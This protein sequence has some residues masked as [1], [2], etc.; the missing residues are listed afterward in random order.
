MASP[1]SG[2][3]RSSGR[4]RTPGPGG[5]GRIPPRGAVPCTWLENTAE[6]APRSARRQSGPLCG[7]PPARGLLRR[8]SGIGCSEDAVTLRVILVDDHRLFRECVRSLLEREPG[9][10]VAGEAADGRDALE[11]VRCVR[12]HVVL[13]EVMMPGVSGID[14]TRIIRREHPGVAVLGFSA[15][16]ETACV[17][18]ML[19]A[20]ASGYF[21]KRLATSA[22]LG[23]AI[24]AAADGEIYFGPNIPQIIVTQYFWRLPEEVAAGS[25]G[26][27][28]KERQ[29]LAMIASGKSSK[30]ISFDLGLS[31]RA[32]EVQRTRIMKKL[33]LFSVA[34]LTKYALREGLA[35]L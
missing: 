28:P 6:K 2:A 16:Q 25:P 12:P 33:S 1:C 19:K 11:L 5:K 18:G 23:R 13:M 31:L 9:I 8:A 35:T 7:C 30:E 32:V 27:N 14:A 21:L 29:M 15:R 3:A 22:E 24:R 26:L 4:C 34:E 20:G 10:D 17:V